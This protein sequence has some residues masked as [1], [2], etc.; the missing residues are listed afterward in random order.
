MK[1][2]QDYFNID[3]YDNVMN[4]M[5][6]IS[7]KSFN[8]LDNQNQS[9]VTNICSKKI[10]N[11][12][13][14]EKKIGMLGFA[15]NDA[16]Y[17][18]PQIYNNVISPEEAHYIIEKSKNNFI[19][20]TIVSGD[21]TNVRK[22]KTCWIDRTDGVAQ[23]II[24]RVCKL[25]N[26]PVENAE[27][28]QVVKYETNGFYNFHHDSVYENNEESIEFLKRGGHRVVTMLMYLNDDFENGHTRFENLNINLKPPKYS[29]ILFYPLDKNENQCHPKAL[30]GGL[31]I[32]FGEKYI[33][34]VWIRQ[35]K[36]I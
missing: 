10:I 36:N 27:Q 20:S 30:H 9:N 13:K 34:T 32:T 5:N 12:Y 23:N 1:I 18:L 25:T 8:L 16:E 3:K 14:P 28:L 7:R 11:D 2:F 21:N 29:G 31:P 26:K 33:A 15:D 19:E 35:D 24:N 17:M 22:S 6:S 4:D